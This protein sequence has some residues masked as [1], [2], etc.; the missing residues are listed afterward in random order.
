MA[1]QSGITYVFQT[2]KYFS[3]FYT[4]AVFIKNELSQEVFCNFY[5]ESSVFIKDY[6]PEGCLP[7]RLFN[8]DLSGSLAVIRLYNKYVYAGSI[9]G[10][11]NCQYMVI[12]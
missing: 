6:Y 8:H 3:I 10:S 5:A 12:D 11:W 9:S 7:N 4:K 1:Y 2:N